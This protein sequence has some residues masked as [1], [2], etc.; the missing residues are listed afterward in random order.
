MF[1]KKYFD[2]FF[3]LINTYH[4]HK[5]KEIIELAYD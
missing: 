2:M 1:I 3:L 4:K 5:V